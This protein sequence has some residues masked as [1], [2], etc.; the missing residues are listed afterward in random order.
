MRVWVEQD[1]DGYRPREEAKRLLRDDSE[2][3]QATG[4]GVGIYSWCAMEC[5]RNLEAGEFLIDMK[6]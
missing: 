1:L 6:S 3:S 4:H 5:H 2:E